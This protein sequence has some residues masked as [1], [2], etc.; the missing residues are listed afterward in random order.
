MEVYIAE[1][2]GT[3]YTLDVEA[4]LNADEGSKS[5]QGP[6]GAHSHETNY[7]HGEVKDAC[8]GSLMMPQT[9]LKRVLQWVN[10]AADA[11]SGE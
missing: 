11:P 10:V 5:A 2:R 4:R 7:Y 8:V 9:P 3:L 1:P 6:C